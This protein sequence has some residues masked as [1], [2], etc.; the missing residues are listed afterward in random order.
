MDWCPLLITQ[1]E[2][3]LYVAEPGQSR[4]KQPAFGGSADWLSCLLL[5]LAASALTM[6]WYH[7]DAR[8][9]SADEAGH[10]LSS[11]VAGDLLAHCK[12][13]QYQW[14]YRCLTISNFYP[15]VV[16]F[17]QGAISLALHDS[18]FTARLSSALFFALLTVGTYTVSRLLGLSRG[19]A[20]LSVLS[21]AMYPVIVG[22]SHSAFLDLPATSTATIAIAGI[23]WWRNSDRPLMPR[24]VCGAILA[25]LACLTKQ[26]NIA[27]ILPLGV[28]FCAR[29][30]FGLFAKRTFVRGENEE[31]SWLLH[32]FLFASITG[33]LIA[34]FT[35]INFADLNGYLERSTNALASK[36]IHES[37]LG[38]LA[39]FAR[40]V[41]DAMAPTLFALSLIAICFA[42][43]RNHLRLL[44]ISCVSIGGILILSLS[45][46][47]VH[48][49]RYL[50][51]MFL[52]PAVY[53]GLLLSRLLK[54][55]NA[56]VRVLTFDLTLVLLYWFVTLLF[57]PY[58][59]NI[60]GT[61]WLQ[62]F[63]YYCKPCKSADWGY[64]EVINMI[65]KYSPQPVS[66]N[67]L[68]NSDTI[69]I[70]GYRLALASRRIYKI[71]PRG[72]RYYTVAGDEVAFSPA[73]ARSFD[74]YLWKTGATGFTFYDQR[75]KM[76]FD[77]LV[78]SL[79]IVA[80]IG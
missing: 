35:I 63:A 40:L 54:A 74:W 42:G 36:G 39:S 28:F 33:V 78:N 11:L 26:T 66:L 49:Y 34:P 64:D 4:R 13:W 76:N 46:G 15:P 70:N 79:R 23:L 71:L 62:H 55:R 41:P 80:T 58:P 14:W 21:L 51:P 43:R 53:S 24:T 5:A 8:V 77:R 44:P 9:L 32:V 30:V 52:T 10:V 12:P 6:L 18:R 17:I 7:F 47:I 25:A 56:I 29:D 2:Q 19:A 1:F 69:H 59:L 20:H 38:N 60:P 67:V 48:D 65:C 68:V 45:R 61:P 31:L 72:S 16:Y 3:S 37:V 75:S 57:S 27:Y 50:L 73:E 22:L